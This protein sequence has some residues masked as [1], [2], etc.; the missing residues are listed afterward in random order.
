MN[1]HQEAGMKKNHYPGVP[2]VL[3]IAYL[4]YTGVRPYDC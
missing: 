4:I 3:V 2:L 1:S